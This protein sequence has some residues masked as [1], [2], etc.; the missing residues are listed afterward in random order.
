MAH[1]EL[2]QRFVRPRCEILKKCKKLRVVTS[3]AEQVMILSCAIQSGH[4]GVTKMWRRVAERF[5]WKG[6]VADTSY[7]YDT[8]MILLKLSEKRIVEQFLRFIMG[9]HLGNT[10]HGGEQILQ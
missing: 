8:F 10:L 3:P 5:H 6:M 7:F 4:Y 1:T 9:T 2:L